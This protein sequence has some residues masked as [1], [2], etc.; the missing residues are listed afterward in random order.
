MFL[1]KYF[2]GIVLII[3]TSLSQGYFNGYGV[4]DT[5]NWTSASVSGASSIGL[6]PSYRN[7]ISLSNP[8]TWSN[9]KFTFLS[10][11][12]N[13]F[14]SSLKN[15]KNGY[16]NLQSA[17]LIIPIKNRHSLGIELH[18]YSYQKIELLDSLGNVIAFGD[19]LSLKKQ[20]LQAGG[21][22]A[23]DISASTSIFS[24]T[25]LGMTFQLLFGS[26]RQNSNL[27]VDEIPYT[28][29]SRLNYSGVNTLMFLK[30]NIFGFD[31]Y[32]KSQLPLKPLSATQTKL[33][34]YFD[35]N[36]N[37][38]HDNSF[39]GSEGASGYDFPHPNDVPGPVVKKVLD[40]HEPSSFSIGFSNVVHNRLQLSLEL[41][42]NKENSKYNENLLNNFNKRVVG[43][44]KL[45]FGVVLFP[46]EQSFKFLD[47]FVFRTGLSLNSF[48]LDELEESVNER[49]KSNYEAIEFGY[50]VGFGYKFGPLGNQIDFT[51]ASSRKSYDSPIAV[52]ERLKGFQVSISISDI[53]FI[54]RRQR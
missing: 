53:W 54:K 28:I 36:M 51:Y 41:Q 29:S 19:T 38:Y 12:Y 10:I 46:S 47:N 32:F 48:S 7:N 35:T 17:Q 40:I 21:I 24:S 15:S 5:Q 14:E 50:T 9:L 13:G 18:P 42:K 26:S 22:M 27:L 25:T 2:F 37:N 30:Q 39:Y 6:V 33:H 34:P 52:E 31:F 23:F 1:L 3:S 8:T 44:D 49:K 4:G 16:S 45:S 20:F 43:S 11:S